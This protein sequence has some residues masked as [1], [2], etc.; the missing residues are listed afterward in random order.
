MRLARVVASAAEAVAARGELATLP[1]AFGAPLELAPLPGALRAPLALGPDD[2]P[3]APLPVAALAAVAAVAPAAFVVVVTAVAAVVD[4][5]G[6]DTVRVAVV[7]AGALGVAGVVVVAVGVVTDGVVTP[8]P[9]GKGG[10]AGT[11]GVVAVTV[12][13]LT[14]GTGTV[15]RPM[16]AEPAPTTIAAAARVVP[17]PMRSFRTAPSLRSPLAENGTVPLHG[18]APPRLAGQCREDELLLLEL[19]EPPPPQPSAGV[20]GDKLIRILL[21]Q[22]SLIASPGTPGIWLSNDM[23]PVRPGN[24]AA[25]PR[26]RART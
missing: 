24:A 18:G 9:G 26:V 5:V 19:D 4:T 2:C 11:E 8:V 21:P 15:G 6:V 12:G 25:E 3:P 23:R 22:W 14:V 13:T 1:G 10:G 17:A 7:V 20:R 16:S